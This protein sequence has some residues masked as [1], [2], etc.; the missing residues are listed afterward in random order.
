MRGF[1]LVQGKLAGTRGPDIGGYW[2]GGQSVRGLQVKLSGRPEAE[3]MGIL[4]KVAG[5]EL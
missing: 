1:L 4:A 3:P 5:V 2:G